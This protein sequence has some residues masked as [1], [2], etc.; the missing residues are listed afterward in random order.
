M[1]ERA[2]DARVRCDVSRESNQRRYSRALRLTPHH[3]RLRFILEIIMARVCASVF[4]RNGIDHGFESYANVL[5]VVKT[6][7]VLSELDL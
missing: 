1:S 6:F 2:R 3:R 7:C 4:L 5:E